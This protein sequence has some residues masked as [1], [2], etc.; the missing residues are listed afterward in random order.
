M[1]CRSR[2]YA[3]IK[4][5]VPL[6]HSI[7]TPIMTPSQ[8]GRSTSIH[9]TG[10]TAR[11]GARWPAMSGVP[12]SNFPGPRCTPGFPH[13]RRRSQSVWPLLTTVGV[14]LHPTLPL[15]ARDGTE[16]EC[17][18]RSLRFCNKQYLCTSTWSSKWNFTQKTIIS[19]RL[20]NNATSDLSTDIYYNISET[21]FKLQN[22]IWN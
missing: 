13:S 10:N 2:C 19:V 18:I 22:H 8:R 11:W 9:S 14:N 20:D 17:T 12:G 21:L 5:V 7:I 15:T 16:N 4:R 1:C 3:P 6:L